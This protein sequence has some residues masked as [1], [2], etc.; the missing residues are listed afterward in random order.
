MKNL[1]C[2]I[3]LT[4]VSF[5]AFSS[6]I[7]LDFSSGSYDLNNKT[8]LEDGFKVTADYGFHNIRLGTLAWYET[9]NIIEISS[10]AFLF[11]LEKLTI[12]NTAFM[13]LI[14]ESSKGGNVTVGGINGVLNFSGE[15][16]SSINSFTVRTISNRTDI[17]NQIDNMYLNT[18]PAK[19]PEPAPFML[20]C[21][22]FFALLVARK[23]HLFFK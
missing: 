11:N 19:V 2:L 1:L 7:V 20:L 22:G 15:E 5:K 17:L 4:L 14:F 18:I 9:S 23:K 6:P 10:N 21:F 12:A 16:W 3:I 8:Y 13:G